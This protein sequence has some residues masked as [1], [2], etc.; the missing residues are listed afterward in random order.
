MEKLR[1]LPR[2]FTPNVYLEPLS[3]QD[4]SNLAGNL[5]GLDSAD[6]N[7]L[8][9]PA[10]VA[11]ST[12]QSRAHFLGPLAHLYDEQFCDA[13]GSDLHRDI[14]DRAVKA[15]DFFHYLLAFWECVSGASRGKYFL[16]PKSSASS[17]E[18]PQRLVNAGAEFVFCHVTTRRSDGL[19]DLWNRV[20]RTRRIFRV[21]PIEHRDI[22]VVVA[23]RKN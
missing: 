20:G 9:A 22:V 7:D 21:T 11:V 1:L 8:F 3:K 17:G 16:S 18:I 14:S 15:H 12:L 6:G 5:G 4:H 2:I 23:G 13:F 10:R 19:F